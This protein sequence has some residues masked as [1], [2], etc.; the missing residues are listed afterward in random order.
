MIIYAYVG[1]VRA[2]SSF[3]FLFAVI[4]EE[5]Q[6]EK[7]NLGTNQIANLRKGERRMRKIFFT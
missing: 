7:K 2:F 1:L 4:I 5:R 6:Q 3:V